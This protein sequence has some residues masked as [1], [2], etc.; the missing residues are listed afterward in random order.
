MHALLDVDRGRHKRHGPRSSRTCSSTRC[1]TGSSTSTSTRSRSTGRSSTVVTVHLEGTP[2]GRRR[3]AACSSQ[4]THE[5]RISVLP[6]EIPES[7][8]VD[9]SELEIGGVAAAGRP[10]RCPRASS[11]STTSRAPCSPRSPR[12]SPRR[13]SSPRSRRARR[14]RRVPRARRARAPRARAAR[15][16]R[17][18]T[19]RVGPA[20]AAVRAA[21]VVARLAGGGLGNP[22]RRYERPATTSAS[23]W[24]SGSPSELGAGWRGKFNGRIARRATARLRLALLEPETY[25]ER[26]RSQRRARRCASTSCEPERLLVVHDE[27]DLQLGDIRAKLGGGLAGHNG[28][29]SLVRAPGHAGLPPGAHRRRPAGARRPA[30]GASTGC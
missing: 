5:L 20:R 16:R 26:L 24:S 30:P 27:I 7:L 28:L 15:R 17:G 29:R 8:H 13:S 6:T 9:I 25:H 4:P 23:G 21:R 18:S 14:A 12:R 22:G 2:H 3:W 10:A 11:C 19:G 1:A